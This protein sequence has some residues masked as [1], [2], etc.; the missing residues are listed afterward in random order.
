MK[1]LILTLIPM[2]IGL[3]MAKAEKERPEKI[4]DSNPVSEPS[5]QEVSSNI[6][7][8]LLGNSTPGD[9]PA[10]DGFDTLE[11][12]LSSKLLTRELIS[13]RLVSMGEVSRSLHGLP[14]R[15]TVPRV[16]FTPSLRFWS[17][18]WKCAFA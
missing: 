5:A 18:S 4:S 9:S 15:H 13:R 11:K 17:A 2:L 8:R 14:I 3:S 1:K 7:A 10:Q 6:G 12:F 16:P